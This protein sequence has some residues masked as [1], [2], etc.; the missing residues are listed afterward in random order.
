M[1]GII[2]DSISTFMYSNTVDRSGNLFYD[3]YKTATDEII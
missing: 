2:I 3:P 1:L